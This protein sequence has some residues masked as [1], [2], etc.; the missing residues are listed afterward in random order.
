MFRWGIIADDLTGAND[1]GVQFARFGYKTTV[2]LDKKMHYNYSDILVL[3]T[4]SRQRDYKSAKAHVASATKE[5]INAGVDRIYKKIDSVMRGNVGAELDAVC[6][7]SEC[8]TVFVCP[9]FPSLGRIV[10]NGQVIVNG[11]LL[12][13]SQLINEKITPVSSSRIED[14]IRLQSSREIMNLSPESQDVNSLKDSFSQL[15]GKDVIVVLDAESEE[16]MALYANVF[17][18]LNG[19]YIV[20]GSGGLARAIACSMGE[21]ATPFNYL[22]KSCKR[23]LVVSG[24]PNSMARQQIDY[25]DENYFP[26]TRFSY[27]ELIDG[28][29]DASPVISHLLKNG[30]AGIAIKDTCFHGNVYANSLIIRERIADLVNQVCRANL[31]DALI[32][33]GG[34]TALSICQKFGAWGLD[35]IGEIEVGMPYGL[36]QNNWGQNLAV[37]TKSGSFGNKQTL[38]HAVLSLI[39]DEHKYISESRSVRAGGENVNAAI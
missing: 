19:P 18:Q 21:I 8:K 38:A 26:V 14:I 22:D 7:A 15:I 35:L 31:P 1:T 39:G 28:S 5:L 2:F 30:V 36:L 13:E 23:I 34:D 9:A 3:D 32:I 20:S 24:T 16:D 4:D 27:Q 10:S 37:V 11:T 6:E 17:L 29:S 33:C 12:H 25:L